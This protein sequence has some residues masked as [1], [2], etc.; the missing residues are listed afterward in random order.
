MISAVG[1]ICTRFPA[2]ATTEAAEAA[3]LAIRTVTLPG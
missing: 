3:M 2:M 1:D